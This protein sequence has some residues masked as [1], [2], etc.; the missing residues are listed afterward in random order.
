MALRQG[1][2]LGRIVIRHQKVPGE[3]TGDTEKLLVIEAIVRVEPRSG[4]FS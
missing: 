1:T 3:R 2:H 4:S